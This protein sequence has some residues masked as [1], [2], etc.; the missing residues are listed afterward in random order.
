MR[1]Q[2]C[3]VIPLWTPQAAPQKP[4]KLRPIDWTQVTELYLDSRKELE[5]AAECAPCTPS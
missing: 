3:M 1:G 5:G 2:F 4:M